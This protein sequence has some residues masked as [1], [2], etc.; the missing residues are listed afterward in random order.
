VIAIRVPS[1]FDMQESFENWR[2]TEGSN[3]YLFGSLEDDLSPWL[4]SW[5]IIFCGKYPL[6]GSSGLS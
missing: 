5:G 6:A 1:K 3:R 4:R 2:Q